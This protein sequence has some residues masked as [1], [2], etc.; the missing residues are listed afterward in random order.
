MEHT[1]LAYIHD[2]DVYVG[3]RPGEAADWRI[4]KVQTINAL[5]SQ[6]RDSEMRYNCVFKLQSAWACLVVAVV[7]GG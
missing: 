3:V 5:I 6:C 1:T 2:G 4:D 7:D